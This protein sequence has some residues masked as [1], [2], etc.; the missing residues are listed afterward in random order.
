MENH[1]IPN[2]NIQA[3]STTNSIC[4][5]AWYARLNGG[6][7]WSGRGATAWIQ[8]DVGYQTYVSGVVTQGDGGVHDPHWVTLI[9]VST[10]P[11]SSNNESTESFIK[12]ANGTHIVSG[13]VMTHPPHYTPTPF[14]HTK[15][16]DGH[17]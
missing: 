1:D 4:L 14:P 8:A 13:D 5:L 2:N 3:S 11:S 12:E 6:S 15:K 7:C 9:K 17:C 10:F 16:G